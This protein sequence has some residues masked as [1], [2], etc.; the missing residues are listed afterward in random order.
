[1]IHYKGYKIDG[2]SIP[3]SMSECES[4]GIVYLDGRLGSIFEVA[5]IRGKIFDT[6]EEAEAHGLEL[7]Q[8]WVDRNVCGP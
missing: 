7:A 6:I 1:M 5:R 8:N 2:E 3:M 4:L